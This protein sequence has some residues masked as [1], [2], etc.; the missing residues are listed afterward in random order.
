MD[1]IPSL[2][3]DCTLEN[4]LI[5]ISSRSII[6]YWIIIGIV[7]LAIV[8]LPLIY[9]D[10]TVYARGY[11]QTDIE[12]QIICMTLQ[13]RVIHTTLKDGLKVSRG[14]TL[15]IIDSESTRAQKKALLERRTENNLAISD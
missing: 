7:I 8:M 11:F 13:G 4:Y 5:K 3:T 12:K 1:L 14:D 6:I 10:I 9:V 2:L 15:I